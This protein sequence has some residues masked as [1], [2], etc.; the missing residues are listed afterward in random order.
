[1]MEKLFLAGVDVFRVNFSHGERE[2]KAA[3]VANIRAL[4]KKHGHPVA[5]LADLQGPKL[6]LSTFADETPV[7]TVAKGDTF[8]F[9][10][11][12]APGGQT[13]VRLPH[14][15]ILSTLALG[16]TLLI[17]DGKVRMTVTGKGDADEYVDCQVDVGGKLSNRKGVNTPSV[18]LPISAMTDKDRLDLEV[19]LELGADWIALSFVQKPEDMIELRQLVQGRAQVM[20]KLEKPSAV[21]SMRTLEAIV[22]LSDGIMVARGDLG[23]EMAPEDVPIM[24]KRIIDVCRRKGRPTIVATQM[25]ESMI[26]APTPTRA[27][28]SDVATA[29]YDGCD[30]VRPRAQVIVCFAPPNPLSPPPPFRLPLLGSMTI[31]PLVTDSS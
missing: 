23:V 2:E 7:V 1:M 11:D 28:A 17:D 9:D 27:E 5:I 8:R 24:Q 12:E 16:D 4:E 26:D 31:Y 13:R 14:P 25:L 6:R 19:A 21:E 10:L 15:E 22:E 20:A 29:V 3:V 18:V 30:G